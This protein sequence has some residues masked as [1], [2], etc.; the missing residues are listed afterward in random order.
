M[1]AA[2]A[3]QGL[4]L[5]KYALLELEHAATRARVIR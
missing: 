5:T 4:S 3:E 2:A 1:A